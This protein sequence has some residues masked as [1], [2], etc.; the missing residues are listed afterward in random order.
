MHGIN[1]NEF[2]DD[3]SDLPNIMK[4]DLLA[5]SNLDLIKRLSPAFYKTLSKNGFESVLISKIRK[6]HATK[7][8]LICAVKRS[9]RI[10]QENE[11]AMLFYLSELLADEEI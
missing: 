7:G 6:G 10:W 8:Y 9:L 2:C 5:E 1:D 11:C 3:A 4:E